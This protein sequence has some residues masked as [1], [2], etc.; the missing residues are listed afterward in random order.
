MA[1]QQSCRQPDHIRKCHLK[2]QRVGILPE[3][4]AEVSSERPDEWPRTQKPVPLPVLPV[5]HRVRGTFSFSLAKVDGVQ[6]EI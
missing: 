6:A 2:P 4:R 3:Y 5:Q 1:L